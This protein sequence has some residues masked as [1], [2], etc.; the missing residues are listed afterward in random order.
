[1]YRMMFRTKNVTKIHL[2]LYLCY[3]QYFNFHFVSID[4]RKGGLYGILLLH[5]EYSLDIL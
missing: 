3:I 5:H 4:F 2:Y 1:M